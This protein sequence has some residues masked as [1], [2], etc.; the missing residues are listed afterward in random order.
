M[1]KNT[2]GRIPAMVKVNL[3]TSWHIL[4]S[5]ALYNLQHHQTETHFLKPKGR[6]Y[7]GWVIVAGL[8]A[9]GAVSTG[10]GGVN[11]GLFIKPMRD[12]LGIG[13]SIFGWAQTAR[14]IGF[15]ASGWLIGRLIDKHGG[16][17]LL[18]GAGVI[19]GVAMFALANVQEGWQVI[20]VF[21]VVGATGIQGGGGSLFMSVPLSNWFMRQRGKAMSVAFIGMPIGIFIFAPLSQLLIDEVGW[22]DTWLILGGGAAIIIVLVALLIMRRRPEDMGLHIDGVDPAQAAV[23]PA[24]GARLPAF[25]DQV[26][27]TRHEAL[28]S[29]TFW[30][31]T[32][33]DG[34]RMLA[35]SSVGIFRVPFFIDDKGFDAHIVAFSLSAEAV[36]AVFVSLPTGW[37]VDRYQPRYVAAISTVCMIVGFLMTMTA[38]SIFQVF[39]AT[40]VFGLGIASF[41]ICQNSVW[42]AYFGHANIGSIRGASTPLMLVFSAIGA[43]LTGMSRDWTGSFVY[44]WLI[45]VLCLAIAVAL[46][47]IT[48]RPVRQPEASHTE[49]APTFAS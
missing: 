46:L 38:G 39:A 14:I 44:A 13:T 26:S 18:A 11:L 27:W 12:D 19:A 42:P 15:A 16:R 5:S 8:M 2:V 37:A 28:R 23:A 40:S 33:I 36:F 21:F 9:V 7:Y 34:L 32:A 29:S 49:P 10:M 20:L 35:M 41:I 17:L 4:A 6:I 24:S 22:R 3:S 1:S 48:P 43:P 25:V 47:L 31:L 30:R 45:G